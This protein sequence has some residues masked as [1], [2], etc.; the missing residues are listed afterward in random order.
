MRRALLAVLLAAVGL[1]ITIPL[2]NSASGERTRTLFAHM[3]GAKEVDAQGDRRT[4]D[5]N[6]L[7]S[8]TAIV[9][10]R[11]LCY[12]I[13]VRDTDTLVAAHIHRGSSRVAGPVVVPLTQP[14]DSDPGVSSACI[15]IEDSLASELLR[16]PSRFYVNL[17]SERFPN[18][19]VRGQLQVERR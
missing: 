18:G 4:G 13:T 19:T 9:D 3:N 16:R 10:K 5:L 1:G 15:P 2:A 8:F 14:A 17:H 6:A 12:G 11:R 7:G